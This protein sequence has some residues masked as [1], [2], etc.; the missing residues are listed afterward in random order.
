MRMDAAYQHGDDIIFMSRI[1]KHPWRVSDPE[2]ASVFVVP[3]LLTHAYLHRYKRLN[4]CY[5][6]PEMMSIRMVNGGR[7]QYFYNL[8]ETLATN[9]LSSEYYQKYPE[10]HLVV[11]SHWANVEK[12][13]LWPRAMIRMMEPM[14][15][16][17]YELFYHAYLGASR[18]K[19]PI[20]N[21]K[22]NKL[23]KCTVI[24]PY[25]DKSKFYQ[26]GI[27]LTEAIT[28]QNWVNRKYRVGVY[29][30]D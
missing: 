2:Q 27:N 24:V 7:P 11:A 18:R 23:A 5:K 17:S 12:L 25:V 13:P 19:W 3:A 6:N 16:G 9:V 26:P 22:R 20:I 30:A 10:K 8:L 15:L 4:L 21:Q 1:Y 14:T 28:L 29:I